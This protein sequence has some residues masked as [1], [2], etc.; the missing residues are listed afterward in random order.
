M[1]GLDAHYILDRLLKILKELDALLLRRRFHVIALERSV[2]AF[3]VFVI[4][5][6]FVNIWRRR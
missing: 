5:S 3:F 4:F 2:D 1:L 6:V